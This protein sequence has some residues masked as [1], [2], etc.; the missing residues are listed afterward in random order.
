MPDPFV[1]TH[2]FGGYLER[3]DITNIAPNFLVK[4]SFNVISTDGRRVGNRE[5]YTLFGSANN[6]LAPI[7]SSYDWTTN[8]GYQRNVR[9][10]DDSSPELQVL[11]NGDWETIKTGLNRAELNFAEFWNTNEI[12]D[13]LLFVDGTKS[14]FEWSGGLTT[15][16][17]ATTD[18]ITKQGTDT[19]AD[20]G[21]FLSGVREV[22]IEGTTYTYTGGESGL[23]LTG[24]TPD[25]SVAGHTVGA[26]VYQEVREYTDTPA[27]AA[28]ITRT[29]I[30]FV[31]SNPDTIT[32]AA[33]DFVASGFVDGDIITISGSTSN[34]GTYTI[35]ASGVAV[36]TLTLV[37]TD[38]L[39]V[40]GTGATVTITAIRPFTNDLIATLRN[41]LYVGSFISR[42][43]E[44][45]AVGNFTDFSAPS[46]PRVVGESAVLTLDA[47]PVGFVTQEENM[48]I[49]AGLDQWYLINF[50]LSS[51]LTD[52]TL[53][54][55]RLKTAP[56]QA[57]IEQS[58]IFKIKNDVVF[59]SNE[60]KFDSLGRIELID[61]PQ[62]VPLSDPVRS[63]FERLDFTN[64]SGVYFQDNIYIA[65]PAESLVLIYN[66][67]EGYWESPQILPIRRFA[68]INS[69]LYGHSNAVPETYKLFEG[70]NDNGN[71]YQAVAAFSYQNG[72][73]RTD[74]KVF[75][76][77][78][79]E[80]YISSNTTLGLQLN[81]D[82]TGYTSIQTFDIF[83]TCTNIIFNL[84][85]DASLGKLSLG[86][87]SLG[88]KLGDVEEDLPPKFRIINTTT[89]IDHWEVQPIYFSDGS[90]QQWEILA[91]GPQA[92]IS[93]SS[94]FDIEGCK[95]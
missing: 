44:V 13:V 61:T 93:Q 59:I 65:V 84:T 35:G 56:Q 53:V 89:P 16:A 48:Y 11:F 39:T 68:I 77:W 57:A 85:T 52:E 64:A 76:E 95:L 79:T 43:I 18:T 62:S 36:G 74:K 80:G 78:Y 5:G 51:D 19:W 28:T 47:V 72:G 38:A 82:Y 94:N 88:G 90:D 66:L 22:T 92:Y 63:L 15:F 87:G 7:E 40:E 83:G 55:Q 4:G 67:I 37:A 8:K 34:D 50:Q 81:Y 3:D 32:T 25:P 42:N 33:G 31:D 23:T 73:V 45:S 30:A 70:F 10:F 91:F 71:D 29:D 17:S 12:R 60:T 54:I 86:K 75:Q 6:A 69:E 26:T 41:Q 24:V 21:F 20:D 1:I 46:V 2:S 49:S 14:I 27:A 58:A 9:A